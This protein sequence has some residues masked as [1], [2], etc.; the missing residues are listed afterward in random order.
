M[1]KS[2]THMLKVISREEANRKVPLF[3]VLKHYRVRGFRV[4]GSQL[5]GGVCPFCGKSEFF[6]F[7][8]HGFWTCNAC[9]KFG[10]TLDLVI[11]MERLSEVEA[12]MRMNQWICG[13]SSIGFAV[14]R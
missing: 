5:T 4:V 1:M 3:E 12:L 7:P 13:E 11:Q 2:E 9:E 10:K 8:V 14:C 6:G